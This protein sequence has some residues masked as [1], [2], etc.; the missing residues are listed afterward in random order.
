MDQRADDRQLIKL[1][2]ELGDWAESNRSMISRLSSAISHK[3]HMPE[4]AVWGLI[5]SEFSPEWA[6]AKSQLK[7]AEHEVHLLSLPENVSLGLIGSALDS[8]VT[9]SAYNQHA[10]AL[11]VFTIVDE[12]LRQHDQLSSLMSAAKAHQRTI[13]QSLELSRA[14]ATA[15]AAFS[16]IAVAG[17]DIDVAP[18]SPAA[19]SGFSLQK[20]QL[21]RA[22]QSIHKT[23]HRTSAA[24][25]GGKFQRKPQGGM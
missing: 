24:I 18:E 11:A 8:H 25:K 20:G 12:G 22:F 23:M 21:G 10:I 1:P 6:R 4:E 19:K 17:F 3:P 14:A 16:K 2:A 7:S 13:K 15:T 9:N 5:A